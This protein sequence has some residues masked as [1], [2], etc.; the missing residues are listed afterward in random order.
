M[1]S[2]WLTILVLLI[3]ACADL[4]GDEQSSSTGTGASQSGGGG[5]TTN[6][7]SPSDG[8]T[9]EPPVATD[10][11]VDDEDSI[12]PDGNVHLVPGGCQLVDDTSKC[13]LDT[14]GTK[15]ICTGG[16][17]FPG[18]LDVHDYASFPCPEL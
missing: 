17:E 13:C 7:P 18:A 2:Q 1:R 10:T 15:W 4:T 16:D 6:P 8:G 12:G 5:D 11:C 3:A 14:T 9:G